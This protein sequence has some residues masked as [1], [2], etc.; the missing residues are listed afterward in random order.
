MSGSTTSITATRPGRPK[1]SQW[2]SFGGVLAFVV[3]FI[4]KD[5]AE[6]KRDTFAH[7]TEAERK[8]SP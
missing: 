5:V 4:A 2:A 6:H 3:M 7:L 1:C 8:Q